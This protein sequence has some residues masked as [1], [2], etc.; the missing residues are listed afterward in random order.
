MRALFSAERKKGIVIMAYFAGLN[1]IYITEIVVIIARLT[2]AI[3]D[4]RLVVMVII[5]VTKRNS[6]H[7]PYA[8]V[9]SRRNICARCRKKIDVGFVFF[10]WFK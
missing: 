5:S 10:F 1:I 9:N 3:R 6:S 7:S 8:R 2:V 4:A